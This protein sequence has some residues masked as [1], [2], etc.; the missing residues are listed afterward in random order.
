MRAL[1][2]HANMPY[3]FWADA[4]RTAVFTC[5]M[6]PHSTLSQ[7]ITPHER[8]HGTPPDYYM[9]K[10][11]GCLVWTHVPK[12]VRRK[13]G[14][15]DHSGTK[16]QATGADGC[17]IEHISSSQYKVYSFTE[18]KYFV[19]DNL[20]FREDHFPESSRFSS[21]SSSPSQDQLPPITHDM[22]TVQ[23]PSMITALTSRSEV[24]TQPNEPMTYN[25]AM[26]RSDAKQWWDAM[27][28]ELEAL[29]EKN[30]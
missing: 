9:L 8:W 2:F 6:I 12:Q 11:F 27:V 16:I 26:S 28:T 22:I 24:I 5:N 30:T 18:R 14:K 3:R 13:Q 1:L 23:P 19:T 21:S 25:E 7:N 20:L 17:F 15:L 4:V 29:D 10:P